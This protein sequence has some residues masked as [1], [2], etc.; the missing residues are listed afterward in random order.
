[1]PTPTYNT[2][3][4]FVCE[5]FRR[6]KFCEHPPFLPPRLPRRLMT[7]WGSSR[8]QRWNRHTTPHCTSRR[9]RTSPPP[10]PKLNSTAK[11]PLLTCHR[12]PLAILAA[13]TCPQPTAREGGTPPLAAP[14][15]PHDSMGS[16][17]SQRWNRHTTRDVVQV[18]AFQCRGSGIRAHPRISSPAKI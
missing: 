10:P 15:S 13:G 11:A 6:Q 12:A 8:S 4:Y 2:N 14:P 7:Q 9:L 5:P 3:Q 1:M 18:I 17:R 16:S